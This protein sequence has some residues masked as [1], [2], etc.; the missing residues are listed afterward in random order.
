MNV[1]SR[2]KGWSDSRGISQQIPNRNGYIANKVEELG[3]YADAMKLSDENEAIDAI[4]DSMVF[5]ATE[6]V[7]MGYD[8]EKVLNEVL[9]VV[10]S[11]TGVWDDY[12]NK[13]Q[14]DKSPEAQARWYKP[15]YINNCKSNTN[16]TGSLFEHGGQ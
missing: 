16:Y 15:D 10:E 12:N 1:F 3:E 6:L 9:L 11:R 7:K 8:I 2:L 13:F 5:D 14:K 4:A